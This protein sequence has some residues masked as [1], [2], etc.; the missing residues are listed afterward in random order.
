[1]FIWTGFD[2]IGEPTPYDWPARSSYFG[3]M[4]LAGFPK[5]C[6]YLYKSVWTDKP[7]LHVFPHWNEQAGPNGWKQGD[8]VD[9]WVY[10]NNADDVELFVNGKAWVKNT[11]K[12]MPF[13]LCGV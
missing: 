10:Y 7:V 4:D 3:I 1:M 2:Y 6:Y 9:V 11:N 8:S 13:I 5:D 12:K